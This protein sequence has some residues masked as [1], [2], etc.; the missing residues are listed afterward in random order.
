MKLAIESTGYFAVLDGAMCRIWR[1]TT[2]GGHR[3][4]VFVHAIG[5]AE[6]AAQ[7]ELEAALGDS[8][9]TADFDGSRLDLIPLD[10]ARRSGTPR[11]DS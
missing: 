5:T 9:V 6:P 11:G 10:A 2:E 1:G 4:A 8:I 3:V 7:A